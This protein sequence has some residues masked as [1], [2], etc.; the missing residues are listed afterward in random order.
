MCGI[1]LWLLVGQGLSNLPAGSM[2]IS[3]GFLAL[4]H[5]SGA[6]ADMPEASLPA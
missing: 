4:S 1:E 5:R 3:E 6:S 2:A